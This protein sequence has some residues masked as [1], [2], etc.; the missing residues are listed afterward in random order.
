M[1]EP[2]RAAPE[3]VRQQVTALD[4]AHEAFILW[5]RSGRSAIGAMEAFSAV[6]GTNI[7]A[8][9]VTFGLLTPGKLTPLRVRVPATDFYTPGTIAI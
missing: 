8:V 3:T 2:R 9:H 4:Q 6:K 7:P 1:T 5:A